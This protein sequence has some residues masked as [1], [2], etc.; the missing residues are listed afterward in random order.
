MRAIANPT[1]QLIK[2]GAIL[3][4]GALSMQSCGLRTCPTYSKNVIKQEVKT[5]D[6]KKC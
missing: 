6:A 1:V 4:L 3:L 2:L 5:V